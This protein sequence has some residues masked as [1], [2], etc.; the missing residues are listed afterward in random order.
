MLTLREPRIENCHAA[1]LA[2]VGY[3]NSGRG[4]RE[5]T[6]PPEVS[7]GGHAI[8]TIPGKA[9]TPTDATLSQSD[10]RRDSIAHMRILGTVH[11]PPELIRIVLSPGG[12]PKPR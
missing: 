11:R 6:A 4:K 10:G 2:L 7:A 12:T 8:I 5:P 1:A 3:L 9:N